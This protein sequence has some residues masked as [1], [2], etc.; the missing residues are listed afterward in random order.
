[1]I[2]ETKKQV[3]A[4]TPLV[5]AE[6]L[7]TRYLQPGWLAQ[8]RVAITALEDVSLTLERG[9]TVAIVG[10]SGS[11]KSTLARCLAGLENPSEGRVWFDG[12]DLFALPPQE[13]SACRRRIQMIF[14]NPAASLTPRMTA[15]ELVAEPLRIQQRVKPGE[16]SDKAR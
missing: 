16:L 12:A 9:T 1:M 6:Q 10:E 4:G 11:G 13:L 7:T 15:L 14:Q 5:L 3:T 2:S 8:K